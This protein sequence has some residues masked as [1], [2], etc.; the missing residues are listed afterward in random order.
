[1]GLDSRCV[2]FETKDIALVFYKNIKTKVSW[3]GLDSLGK[4]LVL[5]MD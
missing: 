2:L 3:I 5:V 4:F 1:M